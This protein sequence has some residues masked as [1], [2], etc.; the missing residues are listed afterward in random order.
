[1]AD[2]QNDRHA[3]YAATVFRHI[4]NL[5]TSEW[6]FVADRTMRGNFSRL[7]IELIS[8]RLQSSGARFEHHKHSIYRWGE[9]FISAKHSRVSESHW[10]TAYPRQVYAFAGYTA[11]APAVYFFTHLDR[12]T[13]SLHFWVVP[14][15]EFRGIYDLLP[16]N[17]DHTI[18]ILYIEPNTHRVL[19]SST[20]IVFNQF[21]GR[22]ELLPDEVRKI[23]EAI[24]ADDAQKDTDVDEADAEPKRYAATIEIGDLVTHHD[25][26][27]K[28]ETEA[29][30]DV[31][32]LR[33]SIA[34]L[35]DVEDYGVLESLAEDLV[36]AL[37]RRR[38]AQEKIADNMRAI[39]SRVRSVLR[40]R[41]PDA[42]IEL[43]FPTDA[44]VAVIDGI[45]KKLYRTLPVHDKKT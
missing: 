7:M 4:Q 40:E 43:F 34:A 32:S 42:A 44:D 20:S 45:Y 38:D 17:R 6:N 28:I 3:I 24:A 5:P 29:I 26:L 37:H 39:R 19:R 12:E 2:I 1:M 27:G 25:E 30:Q 14:E 18:R 22:I 23:N 16:E 31:H 9:G 36:D 8:R 33:A 10:S 35:V 11:N 41:L 15:P 21:A 13:S